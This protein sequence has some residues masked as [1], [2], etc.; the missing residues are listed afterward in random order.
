MAE[1]SREANESFALSINGIAKYSVSIEHSNS[2]R[3]RKIQRT[4][5]ES[6]L[7]AFSSTLGDF[8]SQNIESHS[9]DMDKPL[10]VYTCNHLPHKN[11]VYLLRF[12]CEGESALFPERECFVS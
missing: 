9:A 6:R 5:N 8:S 2:K 1:I 4:F 10:E 7:F 12:L 11:S 3:T